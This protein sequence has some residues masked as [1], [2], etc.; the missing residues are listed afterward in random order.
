MSNQS[1]PSGAQ[2][3][4]LPVEAIMAC[5]SLADDRAV[6]ADGLCAR[7]GECQ[8]PS[9]CPYNDPLGR[10]ANA[11]LTALLQ[12]V[13]E[14]RKDKIDG[15]KLADEIVASVCDLEPAGIEPESETAV[16]VRLDDLHSIIENCVDSWFAARTPDPA[17]PTGVSQ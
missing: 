8:Y 16:A 3:P 9:D 1:P 14:G 17:L 7:K 15:S 10:N 4:A 2:A 11:Q 12:A 5:I 6:C 13:E